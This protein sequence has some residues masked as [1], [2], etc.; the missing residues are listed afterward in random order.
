MRQFD[1]FE[2]QEWTVDPQERDT[3]NLPMKPERCAHMAYFR[4]ELLAIRFLREYINKPLGH[5]C[6]FLFFVEYWGPDRFMLTPYPNDDEIWWVIEKEDITIYDTLD[7]AKSV[8]EE[9]E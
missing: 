7:E 6:D 1:V 3:P 5:A 8:G 9:Q 4:Y 2:V